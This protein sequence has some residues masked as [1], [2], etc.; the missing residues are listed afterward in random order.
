MSCLCLLCLFT[1]HKAASFFI[2]FFVPVRASLFGPEASAVHVL[3]KMIWEKRA[4]FATSR[5]TPAGLC[6]GE[7]ATSLSVGGLGGVRRRAWSA[8]IGQPGRLTWSPITATES[9]LQ[10]AHHSAIKSCTAKL[11]AN[12]HYDS[13]ALSRFCNCPRCLLHLLQASKA[14]PAALRRRR[15]AGSSTV[16]RFRQLMHYVA[17]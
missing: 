12:T 17:L 1:A 11:H 15:S 3:K 16:R 10:T 9:E 5:E 2:I 7:C 8:S 4:G 13:H 14:T 6:V